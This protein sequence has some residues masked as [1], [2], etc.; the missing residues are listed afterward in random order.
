MSYTI[1]DIVHIFFIELSYLPLETENIGAVH[2]EYSK[3]LL[4]LMEKTI[5][6]RER[7][8]SDRVK[9]GDYNIFFHWEKVFRKTLM[10]KR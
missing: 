2:C 5:K 6:F 3:K 9:V 7:Q 4:E 1:F 10:K 8:K